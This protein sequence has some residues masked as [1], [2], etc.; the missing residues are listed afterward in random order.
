MKM[1]KATIIDVAN[2]CGVSQKTV[3]RV[4][5][6]SPDV[7]EATKEKVYA[8]IRETGYQVN[9]LAKGLKGSRTN[10]IVVFAD[11]RKE[12]HLAA[13][14]NVMLKH[15]FAFGKKKGMKIIFSP[16]SAERFATDETDG[17]YLITSGLADGAILLE[18][19]NRDSR[20]E[21]F[22]QHQI[23]YVVFGEADTDDVPSVS[24]DNFDAGYNG[25]RYLYEKGYDPI[26]FLIGEKRYRSTQLRIAG[27]EQAMKNKESSY[28]IYSEINTIEKAYLKAAEIL[29]EHPVR[30]F[31]VS[32][33]ERAQ[34]VYRAI[35]EKGLRI[36]EDVAVLGL[37][38]IPAG[39]FY[40]PPISTVGQNFEEMA[41][42]CIDY[43]DEQ[44]SSGFS[45]CEHKKYAYP[46]ELIER[47]ST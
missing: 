12:E 46:S 1:K 2:A 32:G 44:I 29:A 23:P 3:S 9:L 20:I 24:M 13:W 11:R 4:I 10:V 40:Y 43:L 16:S 31:F 33:D 34:G 5:N 35:Y 19:V 41:G 21:Y 37:D 38:N 30:A 27:F 6:N 42:R 45:Q 28:H 26:V 25:A 22:E 17:F 7:T 36:P 15:L 18:N 47:S 39:R 14:H 8:A